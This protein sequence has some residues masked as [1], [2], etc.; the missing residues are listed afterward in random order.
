[1]NLTV[2]NINF[3]GKNEVIY[4]LKKAAEEARN[5]KKSVLTCM[6]RAL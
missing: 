1:M 2:N 3:N 6:D 5:I 4:G